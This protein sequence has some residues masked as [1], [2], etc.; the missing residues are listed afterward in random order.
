MSWVP[1]KRKK[2]AIVALR[3]K[4]CRAKVVQ[5]RPNRRSI[6]LVTSS[7]WLF[8]TSQPCLYCKGMFPAS[9]V[10]RASQPRCSTQDLG[11]EK[12]EMQNV[13]CISA[14]IWASPVPCVALLCF[15]LCI[16]AHIQVVVKWAVLHWHRSWVSASD[17]GAGVWFGNFFRDTINHLESDTGVRIR[18]SC[19]GS[20]ACR[21]CD[22]QKVH[23]ASYV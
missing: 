11:A 13:S 14:Y 1:N 19:P 15:Y 18:H 17:P 16:R 4:L 5:I 7:F 23:I 8:M 10:P 6:V 3:A 2:E 20:T 9:T 21:I 22:L 12:A